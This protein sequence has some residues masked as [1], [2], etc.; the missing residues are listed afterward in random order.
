[1]KACV[2]LS[3]G[4][5]SAV[6]LAIAVETY[7][8]DEVLGLAIT[9]G[10]KH[11][12]EIQAARNVAAHYGVTL[13]EI[14][15]TPL[16]A[17]ANC[18]LLRGSEEE[19]PKESYADQIQTLDGAPVTTYVPFRN[20]LFLSAAASVGLANGCTAIYYG[21]HR[22]DAA[23]NAYPDCSVDF[24]NAMNHAITSGTNH[25]IRL[26]APFQTWT[27]AEIVKKGIELQVPFA[28]TWSCYEGGDTPCGKCGT[29]RDRAAAFQ[30]NG[31][32]D[33]FF[34]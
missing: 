32:Q 9:Y 18:S 1:M 31:I 6:C 26:E 30:A 17:G 2:L 5:D 14:D 4:I 15:L 28:L 16:F 27:K 7:G 3:G 22:D 34:A 25:E 13:R 21:A 10:Q 33:P 8:A 20:G 11:L 29:C 23:G 12:R 24:I 19:I